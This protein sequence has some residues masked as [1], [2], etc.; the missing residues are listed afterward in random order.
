[1]LLTQRTRCGMVS[2]MAQ[3]LGCT[4]LNWNA[5]GLN[6]PAR[7]QVVCNLVHENSCT[8]VCIQET[9]LQHVDDGII[10]KTLGHQFVPHYASLPAIG[11]CE[12]IIVACSDENYTL[13]QIDIRHFSVTV[14]LTRRG[15][16]AA[17][18]LT[19]V[20]CPQSDNDKL[21]FI[22]EI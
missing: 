11:T 12:G 17:W 14:T 15:D 18:S 21:L 6:N 16:N 1:M 2:P 5:R 19:G 4:V 7:R 20:Y 22:D 8:V 10:I 3:D 9:K 13:S